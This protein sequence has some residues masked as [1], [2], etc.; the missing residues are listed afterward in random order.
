MTFGFLRVDC[1]GVTKGLLFDL[2]T[3]KNMT[4][5]VCLGQLILY[6]GIIGR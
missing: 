5:A 2:F 6:N 3:R 4:R 1:R